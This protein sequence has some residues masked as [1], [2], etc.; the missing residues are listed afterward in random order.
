MKR[1][2]AF[3]DLESVFAQ[4]WGVVFAFQEG[5]AVTV[6]GQAAA[7]V[8][9]NGAGAENEQ[10]EGWVTCQGDPPGGRRT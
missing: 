5:D 8:A 4:G 1:L 6:T 9:A 7:E 3:G 2:V 10:V